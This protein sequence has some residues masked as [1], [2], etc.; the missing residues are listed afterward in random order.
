MASGS[1]LP[2]DSGD[3]LGY[4]AAGCSITP[5][6]VNPR[7]PKPGKK[8]QKTVARLRLNVNTDGPT[9]LTL[10]TTAKVVEHYI[11][12]ELADY[13]EEGKAHSTRSKKTQVLNRW[14]LRPKECVSSVYRGT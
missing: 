9:E 12:H 6:L 1:L 7:C 2:H 3:P 5:I 10:I 8:L 13:G 11:V 4:G 14:I